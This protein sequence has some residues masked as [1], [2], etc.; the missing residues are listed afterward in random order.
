MKKLYAG[1][2]DEVLQIALTPNNL[3]LLTE[4]LSRLLK[5]PIAVYDSSYCILS[6]SSTKRVRD[7]IWLAG[8]ERGYCRC[9][10]AAKFS[11][12]ARS[13]GTDSQIIDG[14]GEVR[15]RQA[16]LRLNH[17]LIGYFFRTGKRNAL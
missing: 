7:P 15:R 3:K 5:K 10:Y 2:L 1:E 12:L 13:A 11:R 17:E 14:F 6:C 4:A 16:V 8:M 9:E